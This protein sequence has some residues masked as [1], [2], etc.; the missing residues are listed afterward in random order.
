MK[1]RSDGRYRIKFT[2][3]DGQTHYVYGKTV[4]EVKAAET[5][6]RQ[7]IAD[8]LVDNDHITLDQ[9][10]K[11]FDAQR[12]GTVTE[13]T[14]RIVRMHYEALS[15]H[16]GKR[17]VAK[18][19]KAD[20]IKLQKD[21]LSE[22]IT[23]TVTK[24]DGTTAVLK[25]GKTYSEKGVNDRV[26]L[27]YSIMKS[28]ISDRIINYNPVENVKYLQKKNV[29]ARDTIHRA[30]TEE[31][32]KNFFEAAAGCWYYNLF[33]FL[34][35]T[36]CRTCEATALNWS[37]IDRKTEVIH[38]TKTVETVD[39]PDAKTPGAPKHKFIIHDKPKTVTSRRNIPITEDID[40]V[41]EDQRK[42]TRDFFGNKVM[43]FN[44]L[45]F[46]NQKLNL[47]TSSDGNQAIR[48]VIHYMPEDK[49][50]EKFT[51]HGFRDTFAT[52]AL[53]SG[54]NP[55]TLKTILGHRNLS[56]TMDLYGHVLED[57]KAEE[58]QKLRLFG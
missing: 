32:I 27:L 33:R 17:Q 16:L 12:I 24:K 28:A 52:H 21:L 35:L 57:T 7:R 15:K 8:G 14:A 11:V 47:V 43:P 56:M 3:E 1:K 39:N 30:L 54:M 58:M 23:R 29:P 34:I 42:M 40:K 10:F 31:E 9:Y 51:D 2:G 37:D 6:E 41:L 25:T 36:G 50:I 4:S 13:S 18:I 20:V 19:A 22:E 46:M 26:S 55:N 53:R 45:I 48:N 38:I 5:A 44:G 49:K